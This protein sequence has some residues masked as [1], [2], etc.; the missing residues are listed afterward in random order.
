MI[1]TGKD[2]GKTGEVLLAM[3][4]SSRVLVA[5]VNMVKRHAK[6]KRSNQKGQI[7][8]KPMPIHVS[9]VGL[10]DPKTSRP[11]R[12]RIVREDNVRSRVSVKGNRIA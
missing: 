3:P 10:I 6:A 7:V 4:K 9:N 2:A 12:V 5:G 11:T 8:E 1:R